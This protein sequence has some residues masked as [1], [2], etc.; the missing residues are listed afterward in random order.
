MLYKVILYVCIISKEQRLIEEKLADLTEQQPSFWEVTR[1]VIEEMKDESNLELTFSSKTTPSNVLSQ[2]KSL[3]DVRYNKGRE[4]LIILEAIKDYE[5]GLKDICMKQI[6][7]EP[8][9]AV[10]ERML[11][12]PIISLLNNPQIR[13]SLNF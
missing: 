5:T 13:S 10:R 9:E 6:K 2:L 11:V 8:H 12:N 3:S 4:T 7:G 1:N